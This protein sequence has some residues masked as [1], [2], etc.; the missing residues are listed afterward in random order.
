MTKRILAGLA[1]VALMLGLSG[2]P[3]QA[4]GIVPIAKSAAVALPP[5]DPAP[6]YPPVPVLTG[7]EMAHAN[8]IGAL[9]RA[10]VA[11][12]KAEGKSY[13]GDFDP[14][15]NRPPLPPGSKM[16]GPLGNEY[17]YLSSFQAT[18][19]DPARGTRGMSTTSKPH[20]DTAGGLYYAHCLGQWA[21]Q[22]ADQQ[23]RV[24]LGWMVNPSWRA[25]LNPFLFAFAADDNVSLGYAFDNRPGA[26][27]VVPNCGWVDYATNPVN[28]LAGLPKP[29]NHDYIIE[30]TTTVTWVG[31]NGSWVAYLPHSVFAGGVEFGSGSTDMVELTQWFWEN[32][33]YELGDATEFATCSDFGSGD[34][35]FPSPVSGT[36]SMYDLELIGSATAENITV[37]KSR[38][39]T[40]SNSDPAAIHKTA[41]NA[42]RGSGPG[43]N[44]ADTATGTKGAC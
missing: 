14:R 42:A 22:S 27:S 1:A 8:K 18:T 21:I 2:V 35:S 26:C 36:A 5:T 12:A 23:D 20:C 3:T 40:L 43:R 31:W 15:K 17:N 33:V 32:Y 16:R 28:I 29:A 7:A 13:I 37:R 9:A 34:D 38:G 24:E 44:D 11:K 19:T 30:R 41:A 4:S 6:K 39:V 10:A 25:D